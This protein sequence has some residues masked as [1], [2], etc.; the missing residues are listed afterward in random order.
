MRRVKEILAVKGNDIWSIGPDKSVYDAI[1]LLAEKEIGAVLQLADKVPYFCI[2]YL[3]LPVKD[4][5]PL[6]DDLLRQGVDF[7]LSAK[8]QGQKVLIA[9][10]AGI[11]RSVVFAVAVLKEAESLSLLDAVRIVGE[12]RPESLPHPTLWESLCGYYGEEV[13]LEAMLGVL[14]ESEGGQG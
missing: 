9:C 8:R 5:M 13:S 2:A 4:G 10:G 11:S 1:H 12:H 14:R 6:P 7:C 3:Y